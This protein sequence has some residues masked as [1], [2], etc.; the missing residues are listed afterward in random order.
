MTGFLISLATPL[1]GIARLPLLFILKEHLGLTPQ[2]VALFLFVAP[3]PM[4]VKPLTGLISDA[5][6][7]FGSRRR[8]YF[9][10]GALLSGAAWLA[11]IQVPLRESILLVSIFIVIL[12]TTLV[13][14]TAGAVQVEQ[15]QI[16]EAT[17]RFAAVRSVAS[18]A[19][20]L[21]ASALG[22]YLVH[23]AFG[24]T[25]GLVAAFFLCLVPVGIKLLDEPET[26]VEP[27][28][29]L[30]GMANFLEHWKAVMSARPLWVATAI[31]IGIGLAPGLE[32]TLFF[33]QTD[34]NH[35][36]PVLIGW[37]TT[38]KSAAMIFAGI[39]YLPLCKRFSMGTML[40][41]VIILSTIAPLGYL[42]YHTPVQALVVDS[43]YGLV[44][45]LCTITFF[46]L[47]ARATP[48]G[49]EGFVFGILISAMT[50]A[51]F[52]SDLFGAYLYGSLKVPFTRLCVI[53]GAMSLVTILLVPL[54]PKALLAKREAGGGA[55]S[56]DA[57][58]LAAPN[59]SIPGNA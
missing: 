51:A 47:A 22:G 41:G 45:E 48:K 30:G 36:P 25:C 1:G 21:L 42:H 54:L 6:P 56:S 44:Y 16:Q 26:S 19:G 39:L 28:S 15:G 5:F 7:L 32:T 4:Y 38:S 31:M 58:L 9:L 29:S 46:D 34:V 14:T 40:K 12:M 33:Y 8:S 18:N 27:T 50:V 43:I 11:M 57:G 59:A 10:L 2:A 52:G 3:I 23:I 49:S 17:G 55:V 53:N 13:M 37:I 24:W 20:L 35:F